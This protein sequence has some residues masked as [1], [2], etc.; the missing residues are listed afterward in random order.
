MQVFG[1]AKLNS[2][3]EIVYYEFQ[4]DSYAEY[5]LRTR[6]NFVRNGIG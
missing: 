3:K 4:K 2:Y 6:G 5:D 1:A